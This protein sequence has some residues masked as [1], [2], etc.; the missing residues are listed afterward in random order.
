MHCAANTKNDAYNPTAD[1]SSRKKRKSKGKI[2]TVN[3]EAEEEG[4][5]KM[6]AEEK[7]AKQAEWAEWCEANKWEREPDF[8]HA[9]GIEVTHKSDGKSFRSRYKNSN[10]LADTLSDD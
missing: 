3:E 10:T 9:E 8:K 7:K 4:R 2:L 6:T 1:V 5:P